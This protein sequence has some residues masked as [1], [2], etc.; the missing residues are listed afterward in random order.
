MPFLREPS[1]SRTVSRI[2]RVDY[3]GEYGAVRIYG[4]QIFVARRLHRA[5]VPFLVETIAH[6]R[7]H[8]ALSAAICAVR[9]EEVGHHDRARDARTSFGRAA[10]MLDGFVV[11]TT[12]LL[13]WCSTYDDAGKEVSWSSLTNHLTKSRTPLTMGKS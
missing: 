5:V 7:R 11:G 1:F 9:D 4:A 12:K 13:I 3:A 10:R 8:A 6:E 2:L